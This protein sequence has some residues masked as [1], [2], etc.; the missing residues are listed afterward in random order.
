MRRV[1]VKTPGTCGEYIQGWFEDNPCLVSCPIDRYSTIIIKEGPGNCKSLKPKTA[2][3]VA[4]ICRRYEIARREIDHLHFSMETEIPLEKGM[5][6][7]TAD[8][9]G[10]AAGLSHFFDLRLT[11]GEIGALCVSIEPSDNLMFP[12]L[13]LFNHINGKI[14]KSFKGSIESEILII[15]FHGGIDTLS[16]NESQDDYTKKDL[17]SFAEIVY[18][19]EQGI[20]EKNLKYVGE[21]CTRSAFL[22]QGRL[23]KPYLELLTAM[24]QNYGGLGTIIGHSGTV[25]GI[26][27]QEKDFQGN[28]FLKDLRKYIPVTAY[29][30]IYQNHLIPGGIKVTIERN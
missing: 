4:E 22:N 30:D 14:L 9:A 8:I 19:F 29:A 20:N 21:A 24:S 3:M 26:M 25:I 7:S 2:K 27:Y 6:S 23:Q 10:M 28:E 11:P 15:D 17:E 5:A 13:N 18:Q 16:F 12:K 1:T